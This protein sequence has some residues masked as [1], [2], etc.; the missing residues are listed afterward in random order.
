MESRWTITGLKNDADLSLFGNK[1]ITLDTVKR[2]IKW[3]MTL[4]SE[5]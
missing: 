2:P 3:L 4:S 5:N 1:S